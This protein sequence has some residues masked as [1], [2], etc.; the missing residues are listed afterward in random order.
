[1]AKRDQRSR[2]IDNIGRQIRRLNEREKN[3]NL[4][5]MQLRGLNRQ[6]EN[7]K[8]F[9]EEVKKL[10]KTDTVGLAKAQSDYKNNGNFSS[11]QREIDQNTK[12]L[13]AS[14]LLPPEELDTR[15]PERQQ[16]D[17]YQEPESGGSGGAGSGS[18]GPGTAEPDE[19]E[20]IETGGMTIMDQFG[21]LFS[22]LAQI[23]GMY[24]GAYAKAEVK[25][26][27]AKIIDKANEL[28]NGNLGELTED[29][30]AQ[31]DQLA[32]RLEA[33]SQNRHGNEAVRD[34]SGRVYGYANTFNRG[35]FTRTLQNL[36]GST[37][38][39]NAWIKSNIELFNPTHGHPGTLSRDER[40]E[41]DNAGILGDWDY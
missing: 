19:S 27:V 22:D 14:G 24:I 30:M 36:G 34:A 35:E 41:R 31:L 33:A 1:M 17:D 21:D 16:S 25:D 8:A 12:R 6:R 11:S 18:G 10:S 5:N 20:D 38:D 40:F 37:F 9:R 3:G 28:K 29:Q 26:Q 23:E 13:V 7:L 39:V 15:P 32:G 4:N 2:L